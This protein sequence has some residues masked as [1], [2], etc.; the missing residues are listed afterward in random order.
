MYGSTIKQVYCEKIYPKALMALFALDKHEPLALPFYACLHAMTQQKRRIFDTPALKLRIAGNK[1]NCYAKFDYMAKDY[2]RKNNYYS[3]NRRVQID[4]RGC[5]SVGD[6]P[7]EFEEILNS[8][9]KVYPNIKVEPKVLD[10]AKR[11]D[12]YLNTTRKT[13]YESLEETFQETVSNIPPPMQ[14][15]IDNLKLKVSK[16][17]VNAHRTSLETTLYDTRN[18]CEHNFCDISYG[19]EFDPTGESIVFGEADIRISGDSGRGETLQLIQEVLPQ[20][21]KITE[22][23]LNKR[24]VETVKEYKE[25]RDIL[26]AVDGK[27]VEFS[28]E[29]TKLY[30]LYYKTSIEEL[31]DAQVLGKVTI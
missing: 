28:A 11:L 7:I 27:L 10:Y 21:T 12:A 2:N 23:E 1:I 16:A 30:E 6:Y 29:A 5:L 25:T 18:G 4:K 9:T 19:F 17:E 15:R 26:N 3:S 22:E 31:R 8:I 14:T 24:F 20:I 13:K